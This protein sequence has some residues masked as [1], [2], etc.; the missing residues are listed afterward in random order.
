MNLVILVGVIAE[1]GMI[2]FVA[3]LILHHIDKKW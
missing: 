1:I 2:G 3:A